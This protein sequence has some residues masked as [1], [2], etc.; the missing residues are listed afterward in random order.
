MGMAMAESSLVRTGLPEHIRIEFE[1]KY[2][3]CARV[4]KIWHEFKAFPAAL[5]RE[6]WDLRRLILQVVQKAR[7]TGNSSESPSLPDPKDPASAPLLPSKE[8]T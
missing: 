4:S 8:A 2:D 6:V 3:R 1:S 7:E 5:R